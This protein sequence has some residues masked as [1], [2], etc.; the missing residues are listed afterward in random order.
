MKCDCVQLFIL[1]IQ[2]SAVTVQCSTDTVTNNSEARKYCLNIKF[3]DI[4]QSLKIR[5]CHNLQCRVCFWQ[6]KQTNS[7]K[8]LKTFLVLDLVVGS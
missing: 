1:T 8:I 7:E 3:T 2:F 6:L 4:D 5:S